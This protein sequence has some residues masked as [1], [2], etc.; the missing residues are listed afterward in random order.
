MLAAA[1][2]CVQRDGVRKLT[3]VDVATMSA[4]AKATLYNHFRTKN[5]LLAALVES[6]LVTLGE[7]CADVAR[8]RGLQAAL[9]A[10]DAALA[11]GA[12]L[13]TVGVDVAPGP[14][15]ATVRSP[16][17]AASAAAAASSA[18]CRPR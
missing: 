11:G 16:A 8:E 14:S 6:R 9:E 3:M 2:D 4:V 10:A 5:D 7:S 15:A 1:A 18:A 13:R 12:A 17:P